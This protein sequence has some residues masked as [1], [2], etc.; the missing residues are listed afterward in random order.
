MPMTE[1]NDA[2][3]PLDDTPEG[4]WKPPAKPRDNAGDPRLSALYK[5]LRYRFLAQCRM[6]RNAL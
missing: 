2:Y 1:H 4:D 6:H 3:D 5:A